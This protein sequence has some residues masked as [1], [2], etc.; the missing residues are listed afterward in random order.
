[1][2]QVLFS[3]ATTPQ[4]T[5]LDANFTEVYALRNLFT[6]SGSALGYGVTPMAWN[7]SYRAIDFIGTNPVSIG[8]HDSLAV[9]SCNAYVSAGGSWTFSAT[10]AAAAYTISAGSSAVAHTWNIASSGTGGTAITWTQA[11]K[12]D[13]N[14]VLFVA[15]TAAWTAAASAMN[16]HYAGAATAFGLSINTAATT[17]RAINFLQGGAFTGGAATSVGSITITTSATAYNTSSDYRLKDD[18]HPI[19]NS[20]AFID[21]L[22]PCTW[23]WKTDGSAGAGFIAHE[24]QAVSPTSVVGS[25]DAVDAEGAPIYQAVEYGSAEVIAMMVAELKDL[26]RRVAALN[27]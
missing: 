5:D 23:A 12:L 4:L 1:M 19:A 11:M 27:G 21:A 24:L 16:V 7:T 18:V 22:K 17:G 3:A 20:G 14:G 9:F 26:R 13:A 25:K 8:G 2:S 6:V 15:S 10:G